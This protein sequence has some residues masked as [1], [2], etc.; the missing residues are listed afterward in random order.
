M[1]VKP[2]VEVIKADKQ[3]ALYV[4]GKLVEQFDN[5]NE[6]YSKE[7]AE[8]LGIQ[9]KL[10]HRAVIN[11]EK[12]TSVFN[13]R[14]ILSE[15]AKGEDITNIILRH[16]EDY[17]FV[18]CDRATRKIILLTALSAYTND[19]I[20][21]FLKGPS[22]IGK[23]FTTTQTLDYFP[24]KD[25]WMLGGI[26]PTSLVHDYGNL[27]DSD[28]NLIPYEWEDLRLAELVAEEKID[29]S[30]PA[31]E[32]KKRIKLLKGRVKA[33]YRELLRNSKYVVDLSEKILVFL[34]V[35]NIQTLS[36]LRPIL[37]HDRREILY[38]FTDKKA[39]FGGLRTRSVIIRGWPATIFC[40]TDIEYLEDLSTRAFTLT[41]EMVSEKYGEANIAFAKQK[42]L[43]D[44]VDLEIFKLTE[45]VSYTKECIHDL[46]VKNPML[47]M[48]AEVYPHDTPRDMRDFKHIVALMEMNALLHITDRPFI[49]AGAHKYLLV[50]MED[51]IE[52][53]SMM[54]E[55]R[56]LETTRTGLPAHILRIFQEVIVP[57]SNQ[58]PEGFTYSQLVDGVKKI[59]KKSIS[60]G[61]LYKYVKEL[62]SVGYVDTITHPTDKRSR[63]IKVISTL[64]NVLHSLI[65][66][67]LNSFSVDK[68]RNWFTEFKKYLPSEGIPNISISDAEID[69]V[70]L[71]HKHYDLENLFSKYPR[72]KE[73]IF[74]SQKAGNQNSFDERGSK[75]P[76]SDNIRHFHA[77][78]ELEKMKG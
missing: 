46:K 42:S 1:S 57:L 66:S 35:P 12:A 68:F 45:F 5:I 16:Q 11:V 40:S 77:D 8:K 22:S 49:H 20:N 51:L 65:Q 17:K 52:V 9:P 64:E 36:R 56:L 26:S 3:F 24:K 78:K 21:L 70:T 61:S 28:G 29:M 10:L 2:K 62:S 69:I 76:N 31:K 39:K 55:A 43:P 27:E 47:E 7:H 19:P 30:N 4:G 75:M 74:K 72:L 38:K 44:K 73:D 48:L 54:K 50:T 14:T 33:E 59:L 41:P 60:S 58:F 53:L 71:Y 32:D 23:T 67:F 18:R 37:S 34:E 25:V 63:L 6:I 15:I 13:L